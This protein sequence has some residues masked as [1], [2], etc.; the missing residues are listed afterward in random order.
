MKYGGFGDNFQ[1]K[2]GI[3][4]DICRKAGLADAGKSTALS[5]MLKDGA[6]DFYYDS[7]TPTQPSFEIAC[8]MFTTHFEGPEWQQGVKNEW[9]MTTLRSTIDKNPEKSTAECLS[10][11]LRT[12]STLQLGLRDNQR[13]IDTLRDKVLDACRGV[14]ATAAACSNPA[15]K[16]GAFINQLQA[17]I[18]T[19][20]ALPNTDPRHQY[21]AEAESPEELFTDRRFQRRDRWT[22]HR[23]RD[24]RHQSTPKTRD[25]RC[26]VCHKSDCHSSRHTR[27]EREAAWQKYRA[28]SNR[29]HGHRLDNSAQHLIAEIEGSESDKEPATAAVRRQLADIDFEEPETDASFFTSHG[30]LTHDEAQ[31]IYHSLCA[32]ST[33]H[34]ITRYLPDVNYG[35]GRGNYSCRQFFG[36]L[37]DTGAAKYSTC[38]YGQF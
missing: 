29:R 33:F 27:E 24:P 30:Q 16:F 32:N 5:L 3:F 36:I 15:S 1:R 21:P 17:S 37:I 28:E 9:Y 19:Y 25:Y 22:R 11:M 23:S 4:N 2:L 6:L 34:S 31:D 12:L 10:I 18:L 7:V 8:R 20:E 26:F 14:P 35:P 38:G 13:D